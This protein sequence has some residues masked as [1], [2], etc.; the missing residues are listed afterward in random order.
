M[1]NQKDWD[2]T[3]SV[4]LLQCCLS[5]LQM[6]FIAERAWAQRYLWQREGSVLGYAASPYSSSPLDDDT[7]PVWHTSL[8]G[9]ALQ[10]LRCCLLLPAQGSE[11]L[12]KAIALALA[13]QG[14]HL[15]LVSR[16]QQ[17]LN[18]AAAE[19]K[20]KYPDVQVCCRAPGLQQ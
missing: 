18:S 15:V 4:A 12:G 13:K 19:I 7:W 3:V 17:K 2:C 20:A 5:V 1:T 10:C 8:G 16:S 9:I 14:L 6:R 11:G